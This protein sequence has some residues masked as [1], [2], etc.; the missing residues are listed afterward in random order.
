MFKFLP[1]LIIAFIFSS[2]VA[3][4][5][6]VQSEF[7]E[8]KKS[9][10]Y[11]SCTNFSYISLSEDANYGK[12]FTEYI[13]LDS[14]CKWNGLARG[15]FVQLFMDTIKANSYKQ[16]E[17][18]EFGNIEV[19]TYLVNDEFYINFIDSYTVYEDKLVIDYRGVFSTNLIQK[20]EP[21]YENIYLNR[22]RLDVDYYKSLV[23]FNF[24]NHYFS[25]ESA[26]FAH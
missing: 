19:T 20:F 13:S 14:S 9:A 2:C 12:L 8:V 3:R 16:V 24:F 21:R 18:K 1:I 10:T 11:D 7:S 23:N 26:S 6:L 5:G 22:P 17:Q 25:R 15:Y 4:N